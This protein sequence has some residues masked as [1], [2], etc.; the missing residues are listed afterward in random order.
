[1]ST[2]LRGLFASLSSLRTYCYQACEVAPPGRE[3]RLSHFFLFRV[4]SY[5]GISLCFR[6]PSLRLTKIAKMADLCFDTGKG[7]KRFDTLKG[8]YQ[9]FWA[10]CLKSKKKR[11]QRKNVYYVT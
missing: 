10:E 2:E 5:C 3:L 4:V 7:Y 11:K 6:F 9:T 1:M 8:L